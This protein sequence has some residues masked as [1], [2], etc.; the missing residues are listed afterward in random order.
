VRQILRHVPVVSVLILLVFIVF[1][2]FGN[3]FMP[4]EATKAH[5]GDV[6]TPPMWQEGGS[7]EYILGTDHLGRDI[8]SRIIGGATISL[9]VGFIVIFFA[10]ALGV[11]VALL[12]GYLGGRIDAVLMRITDMFLSMP[13]LMIA[14]VLAA[15]L[16]ASTKNIIIVL[17]TLGWA[18][19]ARVLRGEVLR[20]KERDFV[21][22]ARV[23]RC[24]KTRIMLRHI[25]PNIVN[26]LVVLGTLQLGQVIIAESSLSFLGLGVPP[27]APAWGSMV[28]DGRDLIFSAWW[29]SFFPGMAILFVVMSTNLLGDWLRIRLDP[30]FRQL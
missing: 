11:V 30:K 8:L 19:Y 14:I 25:F 22:L 15:V 9:E 21:L 27:P 16:G 12:S 3:Y 6:L 13:F 26:T 24:S 28:G 7:A 23:A 2:I 4:H 5:F 20:I 10:G 1:G 18:G 29:V 17:V